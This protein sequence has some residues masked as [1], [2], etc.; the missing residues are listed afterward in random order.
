[1]LEWL[2]N[3]DFKSPAETVGEVPRS[4]LRLNY[5]ETVTQAYLDD[6]AF[7]IG[8]ESVPQKVRDIARHRQRLA[9]ERARMSEDRAR[10]RDE[11]R[12]GPFTY[13][14]RSSGAVRII[15]Y[16]GNA[17]LVEIPERIEGGEVVALDSGLFCGHDEI[18]EAT[19]P[20]SVENLGHRVFEGCS[21]LR[22]VRLS[23]GLRQVGS[24]AFAHCGHIDVVEV[25]SPVVSVEGK[26]LA[27]LSAGRIA[28]GPQ[29]REVDL[30]GFDVKGLESVSV[31]EGNPALATDGLALF[32]CDGRI[33]LRL[34]VPVEC[35]EVPE[36]CEAIGDKACDSLHALRHV[37][38]PGGLRFIGRLAF[39]KTSLCE[40]DFPTELESIGEKAFFRCLELSEAVLPDALCSLG[41]E[42]FSSSGVQSVSLPSTLEHLGARAFD[43]TPVQKNVSYESIVVRPNWGATAGSIRID[44]CGGI[45]QGDAL[46]ELLGLVEN[47][48]VAAGTRRIAEGACKRHRTL[49]FVSLPEGVR[50]IGADA[51]RGN[52]SL[53]V[54]E[55]PET[56]QVIG[57]RA[58]L[59]TSIRSLRVG[60]E[61][62][63]IGE[64]ALVVRGENPLLG[65]E[66]LLDVSLDQANEY[67]Y[68]ESG[69]LCKRGGGRS[70][71]DSVVLYLGTEGV[72]R[73][74]ETVT[75]IDAFAFCGAVNVA[76]LYLHDH[77]EC[78]CTGA[79]SSKRTPSMLHLRFAEEVQ[80]VREAHLPM[81][82]Y[83][84]RYRSMMPLFETADRKTRFN[85]E[86]YDTWVANSLSTAEFAPAAL[87]RLKTPV[88]LCRRCRE[89]YEGI[90][91]RKALPVCRYFADKGDLDALVQLH[92]G[93]YLTEGHVESA[94]ESFLG[95]GEAQATACLFELRKRIAPAFAGIDL[96]L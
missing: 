85:F 38:F 94:L 76:E 37:V 90:L 55:L 83:T 15:S 12:F 80:G 91:A 33:L 11:L 74:P 28:F 48:H 32:S 16:D 17:R 8:D 96:G 46:L 81:P 40:V 69:L 1:M 29:V 95:T 20:D 35:Y 31:N 47:Y 25:N 18:E 19:I 56:L 23:G 63:E 2:Q 66:P 50:E 62:R 92:E 26:L 57:A 36:G 54:A 44:C 59:D 53:R 9:E 73:I 87:A 5:V 89:L 77:I 51:F 52:R 4:S 75:R 70:G 82:S 88:R 71:G 27:G 24:G 6:P 65:H 43:K 21:G 60:A 93:G 72:V 67:F 58:F 41:E 49:R 3:S 68:E 61:V 22:H 7:D 13:T 42:A 86:Y 30:S 45:Y 39:A 79:F 64:N 10:E 34:V 78:I 14:V 84:S